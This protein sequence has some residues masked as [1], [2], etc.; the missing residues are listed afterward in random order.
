MKNF[1]FFR[2]RDSK[3]SFALALTCALLIARSSLA[4]PVIRDHRTTSSPVIRDHRSAAKY[5]QLA[6]H[7]APVVCQDMDAANYRAEYITRFNYDG[8]WRGNDNW[9]NLDAHDLLGAVYYWVTETQT[10]YFIGYGF[11]HPRDWSSKGIGQHENDLEGVLVTVKKQG[12]YGQFVALSTV[13]HNDFWNYAD[14]DEA[15]GPSKNLSN[16]EEKID[17][18]VDFVRD[19]FGLHPV[20]YVQSE[21]HGIY[22]NKSGEGIFIN[23]VVDYP[24]VF[25]QNKVTDWRGAN[26]NGIVKPPRS[27]QVGTSYNTSS[28]NDGIIY[29][30]EN[31]ADV[32]G[33]AG[34]TAKSQLPHEFQVV[35]YNLVSIKE[36]WD[37]RDDWETGVMTYDHYGT[38]D[39]NDGSHDAANLPWK[40]DDNDDGP[41]YPLDFFYDPAHLVDRYFNGLG[42]FSHIYT[43]NSYDGDTHTLETAQPYST[44]NN[45]ART[46]TLQVTGAKRVVVHLDRLNLPDSGVTLRVSGANVSRTFNGPRPAA[47]AQ[48]LEVGGDTV[49][50]SVSANGEQKRF[51][52][53]LHLSQAQTVP[54][55]PG[56]MIR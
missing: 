10:H 6:A 53:R 47:T 19:D 11:F 28:W 45:Y 51:G 24:K 54:I 7:W 27:G 18:D 4:Q 48:T 41:V 5:Q 49:T 37:R 40:W 14:K 55:R 17:G 43:G 39:G 8:N 20:V 35:G 16:G 23:D 22:A 46:W 26:W 30:L 2:R 50:V 1:D 34:Q 29:H 44:Q 32:P 13:A 33:R 38:F 21:G 36:L 31:V 15:A 3:F 52:F 42:N 56:Q 12:E 9:N 25:D